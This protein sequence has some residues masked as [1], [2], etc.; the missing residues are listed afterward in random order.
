MK[1]MIEDQYRKV[2]IE[3][4]S[5]AQI[6]DAVALVIDALMA[7]GYSLKSIYNAMREFAGEEDETPED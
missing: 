3:D 2:S 1:I 6:D 5:V 4:D 7:S